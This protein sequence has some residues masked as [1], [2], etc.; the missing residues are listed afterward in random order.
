MTICPI[1]I[2]VGCDHLLPSLVISKKK[3]K[4]IRQTKFGKKIFHQKKIKTKSLKKN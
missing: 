1:A 4:L 2:A 3:M